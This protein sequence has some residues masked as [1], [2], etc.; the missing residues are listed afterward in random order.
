MLPQQLRTILHSK[1]QEL[2][3][4]ENA[5]VSQNPSQKSK[6]GFAQISK[7][8]KLIDLE[9][10][11]VGDSFEAMSDKMVITSQVKRIESSE[12]T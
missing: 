6:K 8:G 9:S 5:L 4:L 12:Q 3:Q 7:E 2:K 11:V 1:S 10:L